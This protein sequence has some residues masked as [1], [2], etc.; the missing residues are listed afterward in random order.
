MVIGMSTVGRPDTSLLAHE[1]GPVAVAAEYVR[2]RRFV[3][4]A[5]W[6]GLLAALLGGLMALVW[7]FHP[8]LTPA[9]SS[10]WL[11]RANT[12][13][14]VTGAGLSLALGVHGAP[15][16]R[17]GVR[18]GLA[19]SVG[20]LGVLTMVEYAAGTSLGIDH[21]VATGGSRDAGRMALQTASAF[22]LVTAAILTAPQKDGALSVA[23]DAAVV[24]L[25]MLI[26]AVLSGYFFHEASL[27]GLAEPARMSPQTI[28]ALSLI[29]ASLVLSR[30]DTGL[31][32]L[33]S[34][35]GR[36]SEIIRYL[37]PPTIVFPIVF[38]CVRLWM[39]NSGSG[40]SPF[41]MSMFSTIQSGMRIAVLL[42]IGYML[43]RAEAQRRE[44][45]RLRQAAEQHMIAMCA[46]TQR[47]RWRDRWVPVDVFLK[48]KFGY[49]IT[50]GISDEAL[51]EQL[52]ALDRHDAVTAG[53]P[54]RDVA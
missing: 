7:R 2:I 49:E 4:A 38:S 32:R 17:T 5:R 11:M 51:Q 37:M 9:V 10:S 30:S 29:W 21:L 31:F 26:H 53:T 35:E 47:V 16:W 46:W 8:S 13:L 50:H 25:G 27:T 39:E 40:L 18:R 15:A 19:L 1:P 24:A 28:S 12:A 43:N 6:V 42:T 48:E 20:L 54:E 41:A 45:Q 33:L 36:G 52:A 22:L 3:R 14:C 44:E 23:C 34:G